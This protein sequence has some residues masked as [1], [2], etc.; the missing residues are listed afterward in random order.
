MHIRDYVAKRQA[1]LSAMQELFE[2]NNGFDETCWPIELEEADWYEQEAAYMSAR[3][4]G[5]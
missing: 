4:S 1:E 3:D 2:A 5:S